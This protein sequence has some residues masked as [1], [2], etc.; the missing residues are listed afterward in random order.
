MKGILLNED[1]DLYTVNGKLVFGDPVLQEVALILGMNP[2]ELK[3]DPVI[4]PALV[5]MIRS[6]ASPSEITN[7]IRVHLARSGKRYEDVKD[8]INN[9]STTS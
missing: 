1:F 3:R 6:K 2:G 4:G 9:K 5:R 8:L 7:I